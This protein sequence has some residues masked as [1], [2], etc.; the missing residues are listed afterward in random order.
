MT[1]LQKAW[2]VNGEPA[3]YSVFAKF[4]FGWIRSDVDKYLDKL[5]DSYLAIQADDELTQVGVFETLLALWPPKIQ[6]G[7]TWTNLRDCGVD[8]DIKKF[9]GRKRPPLPSPDT[10]DEVRLLSSC[11]LVHNWE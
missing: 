2:H 6:V 1:M 9:Q 4:A 7:T 5:Q 10:E 11:K 3:H 8:V